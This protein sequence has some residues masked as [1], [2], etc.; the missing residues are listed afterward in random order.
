MVLEYERSIKYN[1]EA[2]KQLRVAYAA[3]LFLSYTACSLL[4]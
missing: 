3:L 4:L 2:W 1:M